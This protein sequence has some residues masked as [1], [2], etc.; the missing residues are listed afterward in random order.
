MSCDSA[1]P[2]LSW[3]NSGSDYV[4]EQNKFDSSDSLRY[5]SDQIIVYPCSKRDDETNES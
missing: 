4:E 5:S 3:S 1:Y 2:K